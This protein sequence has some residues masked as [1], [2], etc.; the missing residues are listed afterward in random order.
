MVESRLRHLPG[1]GGDSCG[2]DVDGGEAGEQED[3][4]AE[5]AP[6][7]GD[8]PARRAGDG[9]GRRSP[10]AAWRP[11][12]VGGGRPIQNRGQRGGG[13]ILRGDCVHH[14]GAERQAQLPQRGGQLARLACR[15]L[16][17]QGRRSPGRRGPDRGGA[18]R[19]RER[20][21]QRSLGHGGRDRARD[22]EHERRVAA[23][24]AVEDGEVVARVGR[25]PLGRVPPGL[26]EDGVGVQPRDGVQEGAAAR[27]SSSARATSSERRVRTPYSRNALSGVMLTASI[28]GARWSPSAE[29]RPPKEMPHPVA[30][31]RG[32]DQDP[33]AG[34]GGRPRQGRRHRRAADAPLA[35]R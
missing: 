28:P 35:R 26:A 17:G 1:Q 5:V 23:G 21:G 10:A 25:S 2:P 33:L 29:R 30:G 8:R 15:Q 9:P 34:I 7:A 20:R 14:Q 27:F 3:R 6:Q 4:Q 32:G 11:A 16:L 22:A 19:W 31:R 13:R 18:R 24:G 12:P